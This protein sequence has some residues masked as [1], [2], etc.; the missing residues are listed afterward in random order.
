MVTIDK[1]QKTIKWFTAPLILIAAYFLGPQANFP[2]L[3]SEIV[4]FAGSLKELPEKIAAAESQVANLKPDNEARIIWADSIRRTA[5]SIVF[6]HGFSASPREG[7]PVV[8]DL[9]RRYGCNVYFPRLSGHGIQDPEAF[10]NL[11]PQ[12]LINSAREAIGIGR[13][14]GDKVIVMGSSTGC[15]LGAYLAAEN[16]GAVAALMLYSPNF[17]IANGAASLMSKPWGLQ[18]A[19]LA[20]GGSSYHSWEPET[21]E[22]HKYWTTTYRVE[23]LVCLQ[24]LLD[25][26]MRPE[27]FRKIDIPVFT[28]Y[29]Y[30]NEEEKDPV[31][32]TDAIV[33]FMNTIGTPE[34]QRRS[35]PF[36]NVH[37]HVITCDFQCKDLESVRRESFIFAE[38]ALGLQPVE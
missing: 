23:G 35:I 26:T 10:L 3:E 34:E 27:I 25:Q 33:A 20:H 29:Y 11:Q 13:Q 9:A 19:Q 4:P 2:P 17:A 37:S 6:L 8:L 14:L 32:S 16:P 31:I 30:K 24:A 12:D 18:L 1:M 28:G 21:P 15:T 5:Y 22:V 36:P 38:E 7:D